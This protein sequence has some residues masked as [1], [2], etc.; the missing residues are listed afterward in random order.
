[1]SAYTLPLSEIVDIV[2]SLAPALPATPT[3]NQGLIVGSSAVIPSIG[4]T[5]NRIR[6]YTSTSAMLADG[7]ST[8]AP[9]YI[10]AQ[11]YFG[12][13][14][15]PQYLWVGRQDLTSLATVIPH[16]GNSGTGY[17]LG[18]V[19]LVN[20]SGG[21]YGYCQVI[22]VGAGGSVTQLQIA[23]IAGLYSDGTGYA[24]ST[25]N[26][27]TAQSPS[28]GTGLLVDITAVGESCLI[29]LQV[30]RSVNYQW[31][32]CMATGAV[33]ADHEAIAAWAQ[34]QISPAVFYFGTTADAAVLNGT[35]GNLLSVLAAEEYNR[36]CMIY[37]TTQ[38]NL[39]PHNIYAAAAM[40]G[41]MMGLNTG[42]AN[43]YFTLAEKQ[44]VGIIPE[45]LTETQVNLIAG[46]PGL[47]T[48]NNGN[49]YVNFGN[50]YNFVIQ[51]V[52]S[53]GQFAD[54]I[55]NLDMLSSDIQ[56]SCLNVIDSFPNVPQTD[57]GE[58]LLLNAVNGAADRA[59]QRGYIAGGTWTG[60][61]LLNLTNG[62]VLPSGF[63][64]QAPS[65]STQS[66]STRAA[67]QAMPIYLAIIEAGSAQ[68]LV[69][70]LNVQS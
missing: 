23:T 16:V 49:V 20:H 46:T 60:A 52:V 65:Y 35:P 58:V 5:N 28:V 8:F 29:A 50:A 41:V 2:V 11:L 62:Q 38:N 10:A 43:S 1:M 64:A 59:S 3:F 27:T 33:T 36:I 14:T 47:G 44:L 48:G 53:S 68:S 22:G 18:D 31:Y 56:Y 34:T 32:A 70:Q 55:L 66:A 39:A 21:G 37:S 7:F 51:G 57:P 45:P 54:Q 69:V 26:T 4:G 61:Q 67:R 12:Q 19:V 24:V 25:S 42:L 9:E 63:L 13:A 30:C 15:P 17:N 6:L 40:M